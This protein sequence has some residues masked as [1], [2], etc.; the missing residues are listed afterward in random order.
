MKTTPHLAALYF[1]ATAIFL[2][3]SARAVP[4]YIDT[5][6]TP[7]SSPGATP[8]SSYVDG[9]DILGGERN[10]QN[11]FLD[12]SA[13]SGL[14]G[15]SYPNGQM[16]GAVGSD[17]FYDGPRHDPM[18]GLFGGLGSVDFTQGGVNNA[19]QFDITAVSGSAAWVDI[20]V[21]S[22][23]KSS[24][25]NV[26]LPTRPGLFDI[27]F[28]EFAFDNSGAFSGPVN[29]NN[30]GYIDFNVGMDSG[31]SITLS[32]IS[33]VYVVPEPSPFALAAVG[34]AAL[35]FVRRKKN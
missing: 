8:T 6:I 19:L 13:G 30:V 29:F 17:I 34:T 7:Q 2:G 32:S 1:C 22:P 10:L 3:H 14:I 21:C 31:D 35:L 33:A 24:V 15:I 4:L 28:Y 25:I 12:I 5:F 23:G 27:P 18:S 9:S 26:T 20:Q 11:S 16:Q